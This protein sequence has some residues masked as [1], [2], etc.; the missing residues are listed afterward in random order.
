MITFGRTM[1]G[2]APF[3]TSMGH[4]GIMAGAVLTIIGID[5]SMDGIPT[6]AAAVCMRAACMAAAAGM[7]E[8]TGITICT[9]EQ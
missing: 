3:R 5:L 6:M 1:D 2:R 7:V 8:V 9:Q 4:H